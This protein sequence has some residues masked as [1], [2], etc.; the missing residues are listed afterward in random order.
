MRSKPSSYYTPAAR[1][2]RITNHIH[3]YH[4]AHDYNWYYSQPHYYVGGGY[5]SSFWWMMMEWSAERRA[6]WLYHNRYSIEAAAY[7]RGLQDAAVAA[8]IQQ[9]EAQNVARNTDYVD[10]EFAENPSMMYSQ[11][12]IEAAYNP[13]VLSPGS[14]AALTVL[15][16]IIIIGVV[17]Y[18]IFLFMTKVRFGR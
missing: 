16:W 4:Y 6:R 2:T 13:T 9:L 8:Q 14:D 10:P 17:G 7:Q 5:S 11:E 12:Y 18:A 1:Q 15:L 3:H